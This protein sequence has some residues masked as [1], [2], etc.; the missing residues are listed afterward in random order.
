MA[1]S[2]KRSAGRKAPSRPVPVAPASSGTDRHAAS[3]PKAEADEAAPPAIDSALD[4]W[5]ASATREQ[6][7]WQIGLCRTL[8][9]GAKAVRQAQAEAAER[10]ES[11]QLRAADQLLSARGVSDFAEVQ[12]ELLRTNAEEAAQYWNRLGE[13]AVRSAAEAW[14]EGSTGW[15]R[16]SAAAWEGLMQ[17]TRWQA[18]VPQTADLVEA[19]VEHVANPFAASPLVW[20]AQEAAR[21]VLD[22]AAGAWRDWLSVGSSGQP[23]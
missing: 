21:Q 14:Q 2:A 19:E 9:R 12:F 5:S 7:A 8:L 11:A 6:L 20:P 18:A 17:W 1:T 3:Q 23:H 13:V 10:A 4:A 16:A 22:M 15:G